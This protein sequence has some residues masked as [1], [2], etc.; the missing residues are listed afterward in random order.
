MTRIVILFLSF[1]STNISFGQSNQHDLGQL[2]Y[3]SD[4]MAHAHFEAHRVQAH[5]AFI[6]L[7]ESFL[8][9]NTFDLPLDTLS[10]IKELRTSEFR[11]VTFGIERRKNE[12]A[13]HGYIQ[14]KNGGF[15]KLQAADYDADVVF[16]DLTTEQWIAGLYYHIIPFAVEKDTMFLLMGYNQTVY[17][18]KMKILDVLRYENGQFI[19][20]GDRFVFPKED[21]RDYVQSRMMYAYSADMNMALREEADIQSIFVDHLIEV[22]ERIPGQGNT[23]VP[24][25]TYSAFD[26]K[27]GRWVFREILPVTP[28]RVQQPDFN[29][30]RS[31][32]DIF[33]QK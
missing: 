14:K 16:E 3:L 25:G 29:K 12:Y 20:G 21:V 7:F 13:Y 19:F 31:E 1:L 2:S 27:E 4:V 26:L 32:K 33:G 10:M 15:V 11:I 23:M 17:H 5:D 22:K 9:Q 18:T 28:I 24:D 8:D 30:K 6:P